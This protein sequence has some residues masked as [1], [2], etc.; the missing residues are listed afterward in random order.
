MKERA[1]D[2]A[3]LCLTVAQMNLLPDNRVEVAR[4]CWWCAATGKVLNSA[5]NKESL[6][7]SSARFQRISFRSV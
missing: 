1:K 2:Y 7:S 6:G 5:G 4:H 3:S